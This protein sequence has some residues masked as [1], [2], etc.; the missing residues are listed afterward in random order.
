MNL[1]YF[2]QVFPP[3]GALEE[4]ILCVRVS[5]CLSLSS[6]KGSKSFLEGVLQG[7]PQ[8]RAQERAKWELKREL[9]R[10]LNGS[11]RES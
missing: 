2:A 6:I 5:V 8:E 3:T 7:G 4:A 1:L 11:S 9:K 10:E